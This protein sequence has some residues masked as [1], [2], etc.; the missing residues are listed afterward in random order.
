MRRC[1][2]PKGVGAPHPPGKGVAARDDES[3]SDW[4]RAPERRKVGV[5]NGGVMSRDQ[6]AWSRAWFA[7]AS[8]KDADC[9]SRYGLDAGAQ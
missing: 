1:S 4:T 7:E 3:D 9:L 6:M 8:R 2:I 5:T